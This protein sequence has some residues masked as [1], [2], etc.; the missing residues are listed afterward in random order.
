MADMANT[1]NMTCQLHENL[2]KQ[3]S[4]KP[5]LSND[6]SILCARQ[7]TH[8]Q[9]SSWTACSQSLMKMPATLS[10]ETLATLCQKRQQ[11]RL[12]QDPQQQQQDP[13]QVLTLMLPL[14]FL[15]VLSQNQLVHCQQQ[16]L[17]RL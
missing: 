1:T 8:H 9:S 17:L 5:R 14:Y 2:L 7:T 15:E 4:I 10:R 13:C 12:L 11:Q 16:R 6:S 3:M